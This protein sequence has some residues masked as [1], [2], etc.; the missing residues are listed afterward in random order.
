MTSRSSSF[1]RSTTFRFRRSKIT[2]FREGTTHSF[3]PVRSSEDDAI[4][5]F[6]G[7]DL[8]EKIERFLD[9]IDDSL[10]SSDG[11]GPAISDKVAKIVNKVLKCF[12]YDD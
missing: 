7:H 12:I 6:G 5:V 10:R 3:N 9:L 8:E 2:S 4:S 11:F 1:R